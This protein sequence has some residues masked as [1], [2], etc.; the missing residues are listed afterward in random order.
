MK[1]SLKQSLQSIENY[2][3]YHIIILSVV[4]LF[5]IM[6]NGFYQLQEEI[7][8]LVEKNRITVSKDI[9][10]TIHTW[11]EERIN[12]LENG[13][14]YIAKDMIFDNEMQFKRFI[15]TFLDQNPYF[16][17][18][19]VVIPDLYFYMNSKKSNDFRENPAYVHPILKISPLESRW[20]L[21]TK[22][23]LQT[24]ITIVDYHAFL[25]GK[26]M[27]ICSPI[28]Q[29]DEFKGVM[30]G[31]LKADSIFQKIQKLQLPHEAYYFIV[32]AEGKLL[33]S[34]EGSLAKEVIEEHFSKIATL[35]H[36]DLENIAFKNHIIN[37]SKMKQFDWYVGIGM[38]KDKVFG[39]SLHKIIY[40]GLAL[41]IGFVCVAIIVSSAFE[42]MRRRV[43][44]KQK[45]YE[46]LLE[47]R[48][49]LAEIG[50]LI[51]G[52]NHQL[53][54]PINSLSLMLSNIL[55]LSE[56]R[57]LK[58]DMLEESV[59]A[60]QKSVQLIDKTMT[61]F[62][63]FY[64]CNQEITTFDLNDCIKS[65]LHIVFTD[66]VRYN[67]NF[68]VNENKDIPITM[69]SVENFVQQIILVLIQ[70]AKDALLEEEIKQGNTIN[71]KILITTKAEYGQ[72]IIDVIDW[73]GGIDESASETLFSMTKNSQKRQGSGLGLFF[74][75]KLAQEKLLGDLVLE[76]SNNPTIFRLSIAQYL[77][78]KE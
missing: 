27:N 26:T 52:F 31:V 1:F 35:D 29:K 32:N 36:N 57:A 58:Q 30:C 75:K 18:V 13:I 71:K 65:V 54:Q 59:Q 76:N 17:T 63:N 42:F 66:F 10:Y 5:A 74:A 40:H 73:G 9:E 19:Q 12:N 64:R 28:I 21:D 24:T 62:R 20:Y 34:S 60:C 22:K 72:V 49:R 23:S 51:S 55:Q 7:Q 38:D 37:I 68:S 4:V 8:N 56:N 78:C 70:N 67:I 45:E 69:T 11:L 16:D 39:A 3:V 48:S 47:H 61:I 50:E 15:E 25:Q 2:K 6:F 44:R 41:L 53:R 77:T 46:F 14:K 43:E 33:S